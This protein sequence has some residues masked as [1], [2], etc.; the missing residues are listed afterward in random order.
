[1]SAEVEL[2]IVGAGPAGLGAAIAAAAHGVKALVIDEQPAPGGQVYRNL[3]AVGRDRPGDLDLL[4]PDYRRGMPMIAEFRNSTADYLPETAVWEVNADGS[5]GV[6]QAG[7]ARLIRARRVLIACGATE[8]PVPFPGWTLPGVMTVGAAQTLLKSSAIVPDVPT[9]LAGDGPLLY[10]VAWQLM[11]AGAPI[12]AILLTAPAG[13]RWRALAALPGAARG[14]G[15]LRKGQ[16]WQAALRRAGVPIYRAVTDLLAEGRA[17]GREEGRAVGQARLEFVR[18]RRR[19]VEHRLDAELLLVHEGVVPNLQLSRAAGCGHRWHDDQRCWWPMVDGFGASDIET[20]GIAGDCGGIGGAEAA[21]IAGRLAG[22]D[23]ARRLGR[24]TGAAR[25]AEAAPL[26]R[27]RAR[28]AAFRRF[29]DV[30][31]R[32]ADGQVVPAADATVICRCEQVTAG[33]LR[34]VIAAGALG[35]NQAKAFT[36]CGMGPCQG[37]MCGPTV[38]ELFAA[39]RGISVAEAGYYRIRPPVKPITVGEAAGLGGIDP[40]TDPTADPPPRAG[41][42]PLPG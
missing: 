1:M 40:P 21:D 41:L 9:V 38:A 7:A 22:L 14:L 18:F 26:R 6:L 37:R 31:F 32:P 10:L 36:R 30:L 4:G 33:E 5:L 39:E 16:A 19:G 34:R 35:P 2:A 29:L 42:G 3:E 25:D 27:Q 13:Q 15:Q 8:R 24:I 20:I 28:L 11:Q 17:E 23:A 12:A